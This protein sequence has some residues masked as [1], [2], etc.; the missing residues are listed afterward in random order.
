MSELP[1]AP[2]SPPRPLPVGRLLL[3]LLLVALGAGWLLDA[4]GALDLDWQVVWPAALIAVGVALTVLAWLGRARGGL[5]GL[6]VVLA[7]LL[8]FGTVVDV[9]LGGGV[10]DRTERPTSPSDVPDRYELA[11]GKLTVDLTGLRSDLALDSVVVDARVGIGELVVLV[12]DG[13]PCVSVRARAGIG[14][15]VVF[16]ERAG[17]FNPE[18]RSEAVCLAA[19]LLEVDLSTGLG[20]VEV[21]RA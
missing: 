9:P 13:F 20:Q 1:P 14:E 4:A 15:V 19:P 6:G 8:T 16:G 12:G 3:G 10:G 11:I 17:G 7:I 2:P 5:V 21:R 18:F